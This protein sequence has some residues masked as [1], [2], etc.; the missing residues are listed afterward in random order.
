M[1]EVWSPQ[2]DHVPADWRLVLAGS[3]KG[4]L[5]AE[6][7]DQI[8]KSRSRDRIAVT[9]YIPDQELEALYRRASIFAFPSLDE[10]FGMPILEAMTRGVPVITSNRSALSE[11]AGDAALLVDPLSH[12]EIRAGLLTLIADPQLRN[13]LSRRGLGHS[14]KFSWE[15]AAQETWA[16]YNAALAGYF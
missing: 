4:Y 5:G 3:P 6:T 13:D 2:S 9:G 12:E 8:A 7:L 1:S 15:R 10:G 11:I 14:A 16:V